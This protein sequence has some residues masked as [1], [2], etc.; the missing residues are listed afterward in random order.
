M[1]FQA[2]GGYLAL[3]LYVSAAVHDATPSQRRLLNTRL[4]PLL[5]Q[6]KDLSGDDEQWRLAVKSLLIRLH[7]VMG[8]DWRPSGEWLAQINALMGKDNALP[9]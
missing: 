4:N 7:G 9:Q 5:A 8:N 1:T 6:M 2:I 3:T